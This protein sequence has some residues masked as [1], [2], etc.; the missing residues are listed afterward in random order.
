MLRIM[1]NFYRQTFIIAALLAWPVFA[2]GGQAAKIPRVGFISSTGDP[3]APGP[4]VEAFRQKLGALGYTDGKNIQVEYRFA[5]GKLDKIPGFVDEL[6]RLPVNALVVSSV[7]AIR[8]VK[9]ATTTVPVVLI[10]S[11]DPVAAGIVGSLERPGG[12]IT[13]IASLS[14]NLRKQALELLRETIPGIARVAV[15]W[16]SEGRSSATPLKDYEAVAPSRKIQLLSLEVR[17][18]TADLESAFQNAVKG[19]AGALITVSNAALARSPKEIAEL[20]LKNRLPSLSERSGYA[21]AGGLMDYSSNYTENFR[22]AA[23]YVDKILKG[24]KPAN[25]PIEEAKFDLVINLKTAKQLALTIPPSV[26][27]PARKVIK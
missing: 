27:T 25:L 22:R 23:V 16:N 12:N 19:K 1:S 21:E 3:K 2:A 6:V 8:A 4:L 14:R 18:S 11:I 7:P 15:L 5:A 20:A 10:V 17:G 13:G 9:R 26:L 24:A